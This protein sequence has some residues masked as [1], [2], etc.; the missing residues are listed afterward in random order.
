VNSTVDPKREAAALARGLEEAVAHHLIGGIYLRINSRS[1]YKGCTVLRKLL[2]IT[3]LH[4]AGFSAFESARALCKQQ[5]HE[6]SCK[7]QEQRFLCKRYLRIRKAAR[8]MPADVGQLTL[9]N[10]GIV[11]WSS[12][13]SARSSRSSNRSSSSSSSQSLIKVSMPADVGLL[14]RI[15]V[16]R[17]RRGLVLPRAVEVD[18][19]IFP[20]IINRC[21][22]ADAEHRLVKRRRVLFSKHVA[23][24]RHIALWQAHH[25][26]RRLV[27]VLAAVDAALAVQVQHHLQPALVRVLLE[28]FRL[29][30]QCCVPVITTITTKALALQ[31][32]GKRLFPVVEASG[33]GQRAA[34]AAARPVMPIYI[35]YQHIER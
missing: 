34:S 29:H 5:E 22:V 31:R 8:A 23:R 4:S 20:P 10:D 24:D 7:Q 15:N 35:Q 17:E 21:V 3:A 28:L 26:L 30:K 19:V 33:G 9:I 1:T 32:L 2:S 13:S 11:S 16:R 14:T 27:L 25:Y 12:K 18:A 6:S